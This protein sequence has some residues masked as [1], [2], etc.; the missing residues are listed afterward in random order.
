MLASGVLL[1]HFFFF[2]FESAPCRRLKCSTLAFPE[3]AIRFW[4]EGARALTQYWKLHVSETED[5]LTIDPPV[6]PRASS[7]ALTCWSS[8]AFI[9]AETR[10][11]N[12][13][14]PWTLTLSRRLK[15]TTKLA[16]VIGS[17]VPPGISSHIH[18]ASGN[19]KRRP[20]CSVE[21]TCTSG[22][23]CI[24]DATKK[25]GGMCHCSLNRIL[26][27]IIDLND[28]YFKVLIS[29]NSLGLTNSILCRFEVDVSDDQTPCSL[30][31]KC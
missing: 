27:T 24:L 30:F 6:L 31:G 29:C 25:F 28:I 8:W 16:S 1:A 14:L 17:N 7:V 4:A 12:R 5:K 11:V 9:A 21:R 26:S 22:V 23:D 2:F 3:E 13:K 18:S 19:K 20:T 15:S 10:L